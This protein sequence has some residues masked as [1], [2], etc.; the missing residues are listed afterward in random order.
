MG[1]PGLDVNPATRG[2]VL[3]LEDQQGREEALLVWVNRLINFQ[4]KF[5]S[6]LIYLDIGKM[7]P[8]FKSKTKPNS[9]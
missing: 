1:T 7:L 6:I 5:I 4:G 8:M 9:P 2:S 3:H